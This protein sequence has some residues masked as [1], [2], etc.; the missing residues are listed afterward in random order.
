MAFS[1]LKKQSISFSAKAFIIGFIALFISACGFHL[2]GQVPIPLALKNLKLNSQSEMPSFDQS[3]NKSLILADVS[4]IDEDAQ[5]DETVLELKVLKITFTDRTLSTASNNDVTERER[6]L[7][8][9]YFIRNN[10]GKSLYGPRIVTL[11]RTLSNQ[12]A[13]DDT[14]LAYNKE[15]MQDMADDLAKQLVNDLA[16]SPL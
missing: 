15:Q 7:K 6:T 9:S 12:D 4:I 1:Q 10:T 13:S 2:K 3:L 11:S 14:V 5:V 8:A 16:Y